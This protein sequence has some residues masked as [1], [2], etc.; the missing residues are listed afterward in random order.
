[1]SAVVGRAMV[2]GVVGWC[3]GPPGPLPPLLSVGRV[4][5]PPLS[6]DELGQST[7]PPRHPMIPPI[8]F[9]VEVLVVEVLEGVEL[10]LVGVLVVALVIGSEGS[11][12]DFEDW[13]TM[14][15]PIGNV[16][17]GVKLCDVLPRVASG[18]VVGDFVVRGLVEGGFVD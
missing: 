3:I 2:E 13:T 16:A 14:K 1:M 18:V 7:N 11:K 15:V 6:V 9:E 12:S 5:V 4:V 10:G 8:P 17:L